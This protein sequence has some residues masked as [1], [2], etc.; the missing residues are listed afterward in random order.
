MKKKLVPHMKKMDG[1]I[2][3]LKA[4]Q[5]NEDTVMGINARL[6]SKIFRQC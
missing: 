6:I 2:Y 4:D 5:R 1:Y 3:Q